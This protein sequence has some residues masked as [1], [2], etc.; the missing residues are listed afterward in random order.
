VS[1]LFAAG[2][3]PGVSPCPVELL[4]VTE[5]P[6]VGSLIL[7]YPGSRVRAAVAR[8]GPASDLHPIGRSTGSG[9]TSLRPGVD[10]VPDDG[11]GIAVIPA[12]GVIAPSSNVER[13]LTARRGASATQMSLQLPTR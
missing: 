1:T 3:A 8:A 4:V 7:P 11:R 10:E 6:L 12:D 9:L 2:D 5:P 13:L